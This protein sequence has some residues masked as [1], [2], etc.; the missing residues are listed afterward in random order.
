MSRNAANS[1][2]MTLPTP[3]SCRARFVN[4]SSWANASTGIKA[5]RSI[6]QTESTKRRGRAK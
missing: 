5:G 6:D 2:P 3:T 4:L 1:M